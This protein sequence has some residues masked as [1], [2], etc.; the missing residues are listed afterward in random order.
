MSPLIVGS[1]ITGSEGRSDRLG[2]P[3]GTTD[4]TTA[5]AGDLYYKTDTDKIR[6]YDG[7][8]WND[9]ASGGG[10]GGGGGGGSTTL[11]SNSLRF[12]SEENEY[13]SRTPTSAGNGDAWTY[14]TWIKINS[15]GN[16]FIFGAGQQV[17]N[18][19]VYTWVRINNGQFQYRQ[20]IGGTLSYYE[21]T[22]KLRDCCAWYHLVMVYDSP[23]SVASERLRVYIN[24]ERITEWDTET[25]PAQNA[26]S[27]I[28]STKRHQ[29]GSPYD[30]GNTISGNQFNGMMADIYLVDGLSLGPGYFAC[31]DSTTGVW[32][33]KAFTGTGTT[34]NSGINWSNTSDMSSAG[35]AF[36]GNYS[37]GAIF[38]AAG[39]TLT[40]EAI[41]IYDSIEFYHNRPQ[42]VGIDVTINGKTYNIPG[43]GSG[44]GWNTLRF[45]E[46]ITTSG[47][48]TIADGLGGS[49]ASTLY[50]VRVDGVLML[51]NTTTNLAYGTNGFHIDMGEDSYIGYDSSGGTHNFVPSNLF[52]NCVKG[53]SDSSSWT[54]ISDGISQQSAPSNGSQPSNK[55][56][57]GGGINGTLNFYPA[58]KAKA[59]IELYGY[60]DGAT[61]ANVSPDGGS[62]V[63]I[64]G[65][66]SNSW[67]FTYHNLGVTEL[68]SLSITGVSGG[69]FQVAGFRIDSVWYPIAHNASDVDVMVD[70]PENGTASTGGDPGGSVVGNY[71]ILNPLNS[72][73]S[74]TITDGNLSIS[75]GGTW[76]SC[77]SSLAFATG[78]YYYEFTATNAQYVYM[79]VAPAT[80][81]PTNYP[82]QGES[83]A[84]LND[85]NCYYNQLGS[86][87]LTVNTGTSIANGDCI[88]CAI[89]LDSGKIWWSRNGTW[90][91][92]GS[93]V[94]NPATGANPVFTNLPYGTHMYAALDVYSNSGTVNFGQ[95]KF[96]YAAPAGFKSLCSTNLPAP[97][98]SKGSSYV[99]AKTYFGNSASNEQ[100][101]GFTPDLLIVKRRDGAAASAVVLDSIRGA[102]KALETTN[103]T[104][105]KTNDPAIGSFT[106]GSNNGF[107]LSGTYG[108]TNLAGN[109]YVA[110]VWDAG[111]SNNSV[112]AGGLN[113]S[114]YNSGYTWSN[115]LASSTG[116]RGSEP[117][118][119][120]FDGDTSSICSAVNNGVI[121]FTSP[122]A[123]PVDST[124]RVIV[125]GG[126]HIV[127]VNGG[128]NQTISP[129]SWVEIG[130]TNRDNSTFVLTVQRS[131]SA[132]T[133]LRAVE[134]GGRLL[135]NSGTTPPVNIPS[136][137]TS[138]RVTSSAGC[139]VVSYSGVDTPSTNTIAH[140]LSK[141]PE[142]YI[143]KNRTS[144]SPQG[145]V[146]NTTVFDGSV[147]YAFLNTTGA[148]SDQGSPWDQTPT[149][150]AITLGANDGNTCDAGN[151][152]IAYCFHSVEGFSKIGTFINVSNSPNDGAYAY[153]GFKPR[154][155]MFKNM[156][157]LGGQTGAGDWMIYDT[158]RNPFNGTGDQ[159]TLAINVANKEDDYYAPSQA[160]IDI[161]SN[162]FKIRHYGSS[163]AGDPN[164]HIWFAAWAENP[165]AL[166]SRAS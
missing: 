125:H 22:P 101:L 114:A 84:Y 61:G 99:D 80:H 92:N 15:S 34:V 54:V 81:L 111:E 132:D 76:G 9:L 46:P 18:D 89:D 109:K 52:K 57:L 141:S 110:W 79:G 119:N 107:S 12:G 147:D 63:S 144:N 6:Y 78:K 17:Q 64:T 82:S 142:L 70:S 159:N 155:I 3:V 16:N 7:T 121:T 163:P 140:G 24:G 148:A 131:S 26:T 116:F 162:G 35:N 127:T 14:S 87:A 106:A 88:G 151:D 90:L 95:T 36:N 122:V 149:P 165:F 158:T 28:N 75:S 143:I 67:N 32:N 38:T 49:S 83:W 166:N 115:S 43:H 117:A 97:A 11:V 4:P 130:Y 13:L 112:S 29:I 48:I 1:G 39:S 91:S 59:S 105:E 69:T 128:A 23:N 156:K 146:V 134:I 55:Y 103:T 8:Q 74:T 126:N 133:G 98:I 10:G 72:D 85:G 145:W 71:A 123:V 19:G 104:L 68:S 86:D 42:Y 2:L 53:V 96:K 120:A 50:A 20:W 37:N 153:C 154:I 25:T 77:L 73:S 44:N 129:G 137:A 94:G 40:T 27:H 93:G 160:T 47:A 136:L 157:D 152:Y 161:L 150:Y 31:G 139:S 135:L 45:P 65:G 21:S 66:G 33:P 108:Q 102:T 124:I 58:I 118:T 60:T 164:R 5:E 51:D 100:L 113:N 41:T 138:Y 62:P 56:Y 30:G